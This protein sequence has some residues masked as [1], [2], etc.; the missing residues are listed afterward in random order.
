MMISMPIQRNSGRQ[1]VRSGLSK[2]VLRRIAYGCSAWLVLYTVEFS[3]STGI[4][5]FLNS[6]MAIMRWQWLAIAKLASIYASVGVALGA[7]GGLILRR[8]GRNK[9]SANSSLFAALTL[10]FGVAANLA[11]AWPLAGSEDLALMIAGAL[12]IAFAVRLSSAHRSQALLPFSGPFTVSLSLLVF[13]W[14]SR[15]MLG[16][17]YSNATKTGLAF[18]LLLMIL[19]GAAI[20]SRLRG[21]KAPTAFGAAIVMIVF[22]VFWMVPVV[23]GTVSMAADTSSSGSPGKPNL[24]LITLDTVR[25]DHLS[26]CGYE[27]DTTPHLRALAQTATVYTRAVATSDSAD[28]RVDLYWTVSRVAR[29]KRTAAPSGQSA[30]PKIGAHYPGRGSSVER[31]LDG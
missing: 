22:G 17:G 3:L 6:D 10:I 1:L 16:R 27:R 15:D 28:P 2:S 8:A 20:K 24:L 13:P 9:E 21:G 11:L 31:V 12:G 23:R 14:V 30:V 25:A 19:A 26:L 29:R 18:G 5:L 7:V 4:Q